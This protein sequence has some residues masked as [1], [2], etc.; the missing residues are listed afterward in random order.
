[1]FTIYEKIIH[2]IKQKLVPLFAPYNRKKLNNTD[3]TIISNNCWGGI[4]YEY[5]GLPKLSPTVGC[6]FYAEDYIKFISNLE[7]YLKNDM[8]MI[9]AQQSK[10]FLSLKKKGQLNIPIGRIGD[11]EV[12]FLHYKDSATALE[13]WNRRVK[14]VNF[15][16]LI[17]K[18][19]YM[20]ECTDEIF[21]KFQEFSGVKKIAFIGGS[22]QGTENIVYLHKYESANVPDDTFYWNKYFDVISFI[23]SE[24][25]S[26][27]NL[28]IGAKDEI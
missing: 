2:K 6:Y 11:I 25:T 26:I 17:I 19:S 14:R 4:C 7:Y 24:K 28:S 16:N 13:K 3:F 8:K 9:N 10:H 15:D 21:Q 1:M 5:F 12:V 18:F 23:N 27:T 22:G 20:N